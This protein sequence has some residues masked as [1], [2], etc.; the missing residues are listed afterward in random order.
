[1]SLLQIG[2]DIGRGIGQANEHQLLRQGNYD[3]NLGMNYV[4]S[5]ATSFA[6]IG[7]I[8]SKINRVIENIKFTEISPIPTYITF[9]ASI[10]IPCTLTYIKKSINFT[11]H[12]NLHTIANLLDYQ[13]LPNVILVA[14]LASA[15]GFIA[16]GN[17]IYGGCN[18]TFLLLNLLDEQG[19]INADFIK[20]NPIL[21]NTLLA[22]KVSYLL[23]SLNLY[24]A[25]SLIDIL[26]DII[27]EIRCYK[28][29]IAN[30]IHPITL[31]EFESKCSGS[32]SLN[33]RLNNYHLLEKPISNNSIPD[34]ENQFDQYASFLEDYLKQDL[35]I[36][37]PRLV[38]IFQ[39]DEKWQNDYNNN[40]IEY[41]KDGTNSLISYMSRL[42]NQKDFKN[43]FLS[44]VQHMS[45]LPQDERIAL[46]GQLSQIGHYCAER[47]YIDIN[48]L[49]DTYIDT[50]EKR[51]L[52]N[53]LL[54][55]LHQDRMQIL[56]QVLAFINQ[57]KPLLN[58][59]TNLD[60]EHPFS[61]EN[62]QTIQNQFRQLGVEKEALDIM[63]RELLAITL[64]PRDNESLRNK[65]YSKLLTIFTRCLTPLMPPIEDV[66]FA[67][68]TKNILSPYLLSLIHI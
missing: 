16:L 30:V 24:N 33:Y 58:A 60:R 12:P 64:I 31:Q 39:D 37:S 46:L 47:K 7:N 8:L 49:Y 36:Y 43:K 17:P 1:M 44:L 20:K 67:N 54:G 40:P 19:G 65:I 18:L 3:A 27:Y 2:L 45:N 26:S 68:I 23:T 42:T 6:L 15:V 53:K 13:I 32:S 21:V 9:S 10:V 29:K 38:D 14:N 56:D 59:I 50:I 11:S 4:F 28:N 51:S 22:C 66:H 52:C 25:V 35:S 34:L 48:V 62:R 63:T 55:I 5:T 61:D 57:I 41:L